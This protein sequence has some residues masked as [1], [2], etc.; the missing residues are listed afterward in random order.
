MPDPIRREE[1]EQPAPAFSHHI[2][3]GFGIHEQCGEECAHLSPAQRTEHLTP[4]P[5]PSQHG[6]SI[7]RSCSP[8][9]CLPPRLGCP[10]LLFT[11]P[12]MWS[13][14]SCPAAIPGLRFH[15][16]LAQGSPGVPTSQT[17][18]LLRELHP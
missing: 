18:D 13:S 14:P 6:H 4:G 2:R 8:S 11:I 15:L 17:G 1:Q 10:L 5:A 16:C 12:G 3:P 9:R 7:P